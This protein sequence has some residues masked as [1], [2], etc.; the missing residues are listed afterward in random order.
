MF[1]VPSKKHPVHEEVEDLMDIATAI[2]C[3]F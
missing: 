3:F 2:K 1:E